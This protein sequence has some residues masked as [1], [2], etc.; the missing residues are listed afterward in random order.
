MC[1]VEL[2]GAGKIAMSRR[3]IVRGL[4]TGSV[5]ALVPLA[6]SCT[7]NEVTGRSQL[8]FI[9]D[10]QLMQM[11]ASA[12][13]EVNQ[14][15]R[16]STDPAKNARLRRVGE[17]IARASGRQS[18]PW[19]FVVFDNPQKNAFVLPGGKVGFYSGLLD[20][21]DRDDHVA[22][23]LG[24]EVGHTTARHSSE[25]A[26]Q[27][28]LAQLAQVG[29]QIAIAQSD[30]GFKREAAAMLGLGIQFGVLMPY[31]RLHELE[32]DRIGVD[33]MHE[34]GYDVRESVRFWERMSEGSRGGPPEFLSTHPSPETR[35]AQLRQHIN[36]RGYAVM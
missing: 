4:A 11:S 23:V 14:A 25:R 16:R 36:N 15:E 2:T 35:I 21:A 22:T 32:A 19:E 29:G 7:T 31:S 30:I 34:A 28:M 10:A 26:S 33:Y 6:A 9:S 17:K 27:G 13:Q 8:A 5:V 1:E 3:D 12:W 24:H 18:D 20:I